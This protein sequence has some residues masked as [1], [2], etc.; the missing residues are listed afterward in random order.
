MYLSR[1]F[2]LATSSVAVLLAGTAL[3]QA[4]DVSFLTHWA[5]DTVAKLEAA[6]ATYTQSHPDTKISVRAV[7][8]GDL[9]TTLRTSGGDAD[10][11]TIAGIYDAWL[12]DLVKDQLVAPVPDAIAADT[13]ANWPAGVIAAA[14]IDGTLYGIPNEIDVYALNYNKKLF[15]E[16][17][18]S[19]AAQDLGRV[20][21]RCGKTDRQVKRPAGLRPDQLLGGRRACIPSPRCWSPMAAI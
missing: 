21:R 15:E 8:F 5:P 1:T 12:P 13:Q 20:S 16:A 17:G 3:V 11:A 4:A 7:P 18:I 19:D 9:L 2:A 10:G 6:A 14:T